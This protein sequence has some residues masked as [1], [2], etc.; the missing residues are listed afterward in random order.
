MQF[1]ILQTF[2][3]IA[4]FPETNM[5]SADVVQHILDFVVAKRFPRVVL[6]HAVSQHAP[7][8]QNAEN[9][10]SEWV[11][12]HVVV[13]GVQRGPSVR[14]SRVQRQVETGHEKKKHEGGKDKAV[15][16]RGKLARSCGGS[17]MVTRRRAPDAWLEDD[18]RVRE[19]SASKVGSA[20][21]KVSVCAMRQDVSE[22]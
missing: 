13:D 17:T 18:G 19:V 3:E 15:V 5:S 22:I 20:E 7:K 16:V 14:G 21:S 4:V 10:A 2:L 8:N 12:V 6:E 9:S 1:E 11:S